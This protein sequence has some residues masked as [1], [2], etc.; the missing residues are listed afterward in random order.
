[1]AL[2][3][4][5][6]DP[7]A[8]PVRRYSPNSSSGSLVGPAPR[9]PDGRDVDDRRHLPPPHSVVTARLVRCVRP[10]TTT[11]EQGPPVDSGQRTARDDSDNSHRWGTTDSAQ[12]GPDA[13][14][15]PRHVRV[16][17]APK[18]G[19]DAGEGFSGRG[20]LSPRDPLNCAGSV[21]SATTPRSPWRRS[22]ALASRVRRTS[23]SSR[24]RLQSKVSGPGSRWMNAVRRAR[25][26]R[27]GAVDS[28]V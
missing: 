25:Q 24:A 18:P 16:G 1:M 22:V 23:G 17:A 7:R 15:R 20:A 2:D 5:L 19:T 10:A 28:A 13:V 9:S 6:P 3:E 14:R 26:C 8:S 27:A 11:I 4:R 21:D 12:L